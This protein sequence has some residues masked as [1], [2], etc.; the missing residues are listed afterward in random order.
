MFVDH[1]V[2]QS[3]AKGP[4]PTER[5]Y[6][7]QFEQAAVTDHIREDHGDKLS[8]ARCPSDQV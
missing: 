6:I 4:K 2:D 8:T 5:S 7:I 3:V 1:R